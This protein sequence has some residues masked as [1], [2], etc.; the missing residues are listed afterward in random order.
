[1]NK[2][3][4]EYKKSMNERQISYFENNATIEKLFAFLMAN[5]KID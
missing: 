4:D 3:F 2:E 5:N 1:M